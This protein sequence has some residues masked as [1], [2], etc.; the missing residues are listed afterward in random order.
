M[1]SH[2]PIPPPGQEPKDTTPVIVAGKDEGEVDNDYFLLP[3]PVR[4]H[5]GPLENKFAVENRLLPH[6]GCAGVCGGVEWSGWGGVGWVGV[7]WVEWSAAGGGRSVGVCGITSL[8]SS[9]LPLLRSPPPPTTCPTPAPPPTPHR[10]GV[11]ELKA[12]LQARRAAPFVARISDFHLLLWL[13]RQPNL[14]LAEVGVLGDAV[15]AKRAVPE[16][17]QLIIDSMAGLL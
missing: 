14:D 17:F 16:G 7:E 11:A 15:A 5:E 4:D 13:A 12:H 2:P 6:G 9:L 1:L 10:T 8:S 3:V